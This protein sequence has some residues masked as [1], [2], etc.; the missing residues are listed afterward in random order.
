VQ[1]H[2]MHA[3]REGLD[4]HELVL[5]DPAIAGRVPRAKIEHAFDLKRQLRNIDKIFARVFPQKVAKR[6][7]AKRAGVKRGVKKRS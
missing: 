6:P 1:G 3:W 7:A 5:E 2:A 4:F